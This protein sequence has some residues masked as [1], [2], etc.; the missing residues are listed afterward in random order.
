MPEDGRPPQGSGFVIRD[1]RTTDIDALARLETERFASDRLSRRS[2]RSLMRSP[3]ACL[4]VATRGED[5]VGYA[6]LLIRRGSRSARLY[7]IAVAAEAAGRGVGSRLLSA[8]EE[9]ARQRGA[10]R[11]RLEVRADNPAVAG[12]YERAGYQPVGHRP[13]YYGDGMRALLLAR[14]LSNG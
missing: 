13:G 12:F 14:K 2:L 10:D 11:L 3:S 5:P 9:M 8:I 6:V 7:S 4:L 1:A